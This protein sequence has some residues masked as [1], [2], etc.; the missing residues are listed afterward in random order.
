MADCQVRAQIERRIGAAVGGEDLAQSHPPH[1]PVGRGDVREN[2]VLL[3]VGNDGAGHPP[4]AGGGVVH[5]FGFEK[6]QIG[7]GN[8]HGVLG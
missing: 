7:F 4:T 6:D 2:V 8:R 3:A 1:H 5:P